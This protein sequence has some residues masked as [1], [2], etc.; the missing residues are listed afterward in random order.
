MNKGWFSKRIFKEF[1]SFV[2]LIYKWLWCQ[3]RS[4]FPFRL[5]SKQDPIHKLLVFTNS[6]N[7]F[8]DE[9]SLQSVLIAGIS[10]WSSNFYSYFLPASS[11]SWS[12][13]IWNF[14]NYIVK[15][16]STDNTL[17]TVLFN[18]PSENSRKTFRLTWV[19]FETFWTCQSTVRERL[20]PARR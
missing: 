11:I 9:R 13:L 14:D 18:Y 2:T 3:T 10:S 4:K 1:L 7:K 16:L 15:P 5:T 20:T 19:Y 8:M 6:A 17:S 12:R